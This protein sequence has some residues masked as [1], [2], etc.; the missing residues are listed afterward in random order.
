MPD[1]R[2]FAT[3]ARDPP[4]N[5]ARHPAF[6][7]KTTIAPKTEGG[8]DAFQSNRGRCSCCTPSISRGRANVAQFV[9]APYVAE[10]CS[11]LEGSGAPL[12]RKYCG[13]V[14]ERLISDGDA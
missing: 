8:V 4:T 10:R 13:P 9:T 2:T 12:A 7:R 3:K 6:G 11:R 1:L 5:A 14:T